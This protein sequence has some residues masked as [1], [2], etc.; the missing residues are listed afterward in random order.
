M[1]AFAIRKNV[2]VKRL[3]VQLWETIQPKLDALAER[4][5]KVQDREVEM[6]DENQSEQA[7]RGQALTTE[8]D[9]L[10]GTTMAS[11]MDDLYF[12]RRMVNA[13]NVSVQSAF[14]CLLHLANERGLAFEQEERKGGHR[15]DAQTAKEANFKIEM[16]QPEEQ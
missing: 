12:G 6:V 8:A 14:I 7:R 13:N 15:R 5:T 11:L 3:K 1:N 4:V 16:A 10:E 2:D 9:R